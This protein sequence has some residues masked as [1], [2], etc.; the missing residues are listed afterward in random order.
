MH[1]KIA[2]VP[3][4]TVMDGGLASTRR[5]KVGCCCTAT[6]AAAMRIH[7]HFTKPFL[8]PRR[9]ARFWSGDPEA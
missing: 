1:F 6:L 8:R 7:L 2:V 3:P 9:S 5:M 4:Q